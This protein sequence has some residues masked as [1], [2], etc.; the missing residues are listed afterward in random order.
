MYV[1]IYCL[2]VGITVGLFV[3]SLGGFLLKAK[4]KNV[5]KKNKQTKVW[6]IASLFV[7]MI[8]PLQNHHCF[9]QNSYLCLGNSCLKKR[10]LKEKFEL[11]QLKQMKQTRKH[12]ILLSLSTQY[13]MIVQHKSHMCLVKI[14]LHMR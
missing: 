13:K 2:F 8:V 14:N 5:K 7:R 6:M 9:L 10:K 12:F 3:C 11:I 1:C 4:K